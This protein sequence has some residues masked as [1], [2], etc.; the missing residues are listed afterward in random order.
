MLAV[1]ASCYFETI[2]RK[3][4]ISRGWSESGADWSIIVR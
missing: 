1:S 4:M 2:E 3:W